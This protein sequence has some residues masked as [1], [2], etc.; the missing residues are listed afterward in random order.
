M[1]KWDYKSVDCLGGTLDEKLALVDLVHEHN[2][3]VI[4][5]RFVLGIFAWLALCGVTAWWLL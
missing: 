4:E 2:T 3:T 5:F 1:R